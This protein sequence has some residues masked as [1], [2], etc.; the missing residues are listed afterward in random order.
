M[1]DMGLR[2]ADWYAAATLRERIALQFLD[3]PKGGAALNADLSSRRLQRWRSQAPFENEALFLQRLAADGLTLE[4]FAAILGQT[5][6]SIHE[7]SAEPPAWLMRLDE[8]F[9]ARGPQ[10]AD[11]CGEL[12][13]TILPLIRHYQQRLRA[14]LLTCTAQY[15][16]A[17]FDIATIEGHLWSH[18]LSQLHW[19]LSRTLVLELH[20][21][22]L[23]GWLEGAS[24]E[25]RFESFVRRL[26]QPQQMLALLQEY[27]VLARHLTE[28]L[29]RSVEVCCEFLQRLCADWADICAT[30]CP[31]GSPGTLTQIT[32]GGDMHHGGRAVLIVTFSSGFRIV[33]K[34]KPLHVEAHFQELLRWLNARSELP[35]FR[36]LTVL[37]RATY[38]W[39]E[40][41]EAQGC[42]DRAQVRRFYLR[43]GGFL[44]LLYALR[45]TDFHHENLIAAGEQPVLIDIEAIFHPRPATLDLSQSSIVAGQMMD[46]SVLGIGLLPHRVWLD[47]A[48]EGIDIS[49]IGATDGQLSPI[50]VLRW[51]GTGT[52]QMRFERQRIRMSAEKHRPRVADLEIDTLDYLDDI[53]DGFTRMYRLLLEHRGELLA[54]TGPLAPFADDEIRVILRSTQTYG[55]LLQ[56]SFH[57][58]VLRDAL[59]RD[60]LLD[61]LWG[62]VEQ[63]PYLAKVIPAERADLWRGDIPMFTTRPGSCDLWTGAGA[64]IG[65]F[66]AQSGLA[67]VR[68]QIGRLGEKDL[69]QQRWFIRASFSTVAMKD[70]HW[71]G[72]LAAPASRPAPATPQHLLAAA[73]RVGDRLDTLAVRGESDAGWIGVSLVRETYWTLTPLGLDLYNGVPGVVLFLA[74]LGKVTGSA[75]YTALA[76]AALANMRGQIEAHRSYFR[77]IGGFCGW[78]GVIY[79]LAHLSA[80]WDAPELL[81]EAMALV[82]L[83]PPLIEQDGTFDIINGSAGC[84]G[85]LLSLYRLRPAAAVL[86]AAVQCGDHLLAS[87]QRMEHGLGWKPH[88]D[89]GQPL[90]GFSHGAAGIAWALL[91]VAALTGECRFLHGAL[92]ALAYERSHFSPEFDNWPDLR[93]PEELGAAGEGEQARFMTAWC[94]GAP[95]IGLA[96]L[97]MLPHVDTAAC[98]SEIEAA[99]RS[100]LATGFGHNFSLCHGDLGN[101]EFLFEASQK[102]GLRGLAEQVERRAAILL[103][104]IED[105]G[106]IC[107]V[108]LGVETPGLMTGLAGI[109]YGLLRLAAPARVPSVAI[110]EPPL[111]RNVC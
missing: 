89:A 80:L 109:G 40:F 87:A 85:G 41:V 99:V 107:G 8:A 108:P 68:Q 28:S 2:Q 45:A 59:D 60:R 10:E 39:V 72:Q 42:V 30:F 74:Y 92:D 98:C 21:A 67:L 6:A 106:W 51:E 66:F 9:T 111:P 25:A 17:P 27:P 76:R 20:V 38:G 47:E 65:Q 94:H 64:T 56:E 70:A 61:R 1:I 44:A 79:T 90:L 102:L 86:D 81:D 14:E 78:G 101:L 63:Q 18:C 48:F 37:N 23:Q 100:T 103:A 22:R 52:D 82:A 69:A 83:L 93:E 71:V 19:Q 34:P 62:V 105:R 33:Y 3:R 58:D 95:G 110:L 57:P 53:L 13:D 24:P 11:R 4:S 35:P 88:A 16:T 54:D 91:Q 12:L 96:R 29:E 36:T 73:R 46:T 77:P 104:S 15:P 84:I 55:R 97:S 32:V 50:A 26:R 7:R 49:G 43:Q 75:H 31:Q 5:A